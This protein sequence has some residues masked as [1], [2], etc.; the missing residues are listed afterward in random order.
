MTEDKK[1]RLLDKIRKLLALATSPNENEAMA[2][3][4]KVASLLAE[5]NLSMDEVTAKESNGPLL[6]VDGVKTSSVP[7]RR[8]IAVNVAALYFSK[9][10]FQFWKEPTT[11]RPC[12]YVRYDLHHFFGEKHNVDIA[13]LMF[14]YLMKTTER[15]A[16]EGSMKVAAK[17]RTSYM[18]SFKHA[19]SIRLSQRLADRL[20][21]ARAGAVK[22]ENTGTT[23]PAL[24]DLYDRTDKALSVFVKQ[25]MGNTSIKKVKPTFNDMLGMADGRAAGDKIGLDGQIAGEKGPTHLL[26]SK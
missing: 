15:L 24:A 17:G 26:P 25:S 13:I 4:S 12:G 9:Y 5:H 6:G 8:G 18:T 19:C 22:S 11:T 21:A 10:V 3:A 14:K 2:A 23:L 16:K 20:A 7:W 1:A